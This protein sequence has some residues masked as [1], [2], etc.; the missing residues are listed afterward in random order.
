MRILVTG[1]TGYLGRAIVSALLRRGHEPIVFARRPGAVEGA[2]AVAGDVTDAAGLARAARDADAICHSAALVSV[3]QRDASRFDAVNV[4]GLRH[5]IAAA[6]A[7]GHDRFACTSSFL[8]LPPQ[9][10]QTPI[11][12]NDYQRTKAAA[13]AVA[14]EAAG[15]GFPIVR[16]YPGVVYG[17]GEY[18][19]GN[20]VGRLVRDQITGRLPAIVGG[21]RIW[22]FSWI[23]DVAAAHVAALERAPGAARFMLGGENRPQRDLFALVRASTGARL[24]RDVP[25]SL[26]RVLGATD[27]LRARLTGRD[28]QVTPATVAIF[29]HD[30]PLDSTP[31][32]RELDYRITPLAEGVARLLASLDYGA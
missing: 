7:A 11:R 15:R 25:P 4:G 14:A 24:P 19:D 27:L 23:D 20:L 8:A 10:S 17:P 26:V 32:T 21:S 1:G 3:W 29:E 2:R 9:G 6:M 18:R 12:A 16:L 5:A 22:S 30:W 31:A 13:D 28:P